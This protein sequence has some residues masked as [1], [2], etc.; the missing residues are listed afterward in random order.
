MLAYWMVLVAGAEWSGAGSLWRA[1][2]FGW[3]IGGA[4]GMCPGNA[5]MQRG[6][7][8]VHRVVKEPH[9]RGLHPGKPD[10]GHS[11]RSFVLASQSHSPSGQARWG[12]SVNCLLLILRNLQNNNPM[13]AAQDRGALDGAALSGLGICWDSVPRAALASRVKGPYS[14]HAAS[15]LTL[16][17]NIAHLRCFRCSR[18]RSFLI[19]AAVFGS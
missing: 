12:L 17:Y 6:C 16:G 2:V 15:S 11:P 19:A 13:R 18:S 9:K 10:G 4:L 14:P 5:G 3:H 7:A 8:S 1:K